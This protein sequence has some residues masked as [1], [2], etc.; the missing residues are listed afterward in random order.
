MKRL[1]TLL[2][3]LILALSISVPAL[4]QVTKTWNGERY[5]D[6]MD[7]EFV[8]DEDAVG[9]WNV[10]DFVETPKNYDPAKPVSGANGAVYFRN[11]FN[12]NGTVSARIGD[13]TFSFRWTKGYM[14]W[15][16]GNWDTVIPSYEIQNIN[17]SL[18]MF[19][20]WKSGDYTIRGS[21][22]LSYY[23]FKKE[24]GETATPPGTP[25]PALADLSS[26]SDWAKEGLT[27]ALAKGFV[28]ADIQSDY[29]AGI[30]RAE[31][32]K[33]A[34]SWL[35]YLTGKDTATILS[36]RGMMIVTEGVFS[37]TND[38]DIIA[39][40]ALGITGGTVAPTADTPGLFNPDGG[41]DRES[42]ATMIMNTCRAAGM[43][44]SNIADT[45]FTD[46]GL[47]NSWTVDGINFCYNAGIMGGV[48]TSEL[49]FEP[50]RSYSREMS[51]LTFDKIKVTPAPIVS[52]AEIIDSIVI[53]SNQLTLGEN[54]PWIATNTE[55]VV[56]RSNGNF[57]ILQDVSWNPEGYAKSNTQYAATITVKAAKGYEFGDNVKVTVS[58][59]PA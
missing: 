52:N 51:I 4:A 24:G 28:T 49:V 14:I 6:S 35:R 56:T 9:R 30:T 2:L 26:A 45:G 40:F 1:T 25:Q 15:D 19:V 16:K 55:G 36:D 57:N 33:L 59:G 17:G 12:A 50:K 34:V 41:F 48:S 23:V 43:D 18:Y 27:T 29:T 37:D 8:L 47:A 32:C 5:I 10:C 3:S 22:S 7:Y 31:F 38:Y 54:L 39:A 42:A 21:E 11:T 20:Q 46:I 53:F 13:Q 58:A 44:V